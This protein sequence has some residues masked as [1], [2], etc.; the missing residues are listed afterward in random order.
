MVRIGSSRVV[1]R[2]NMFLNKEGVDAPLWE[3]GFT[4]E[5]TT[6]QRLYYNCGYDCR[7]YVTL[8]EASMNEALRDLDSKISQMSEKDL[9]KLN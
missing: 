3:Y 6:V 7:S 5:E 4:K 2:L 1:L 8:M 9:R